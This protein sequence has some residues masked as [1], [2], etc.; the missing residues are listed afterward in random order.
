M[1][2]ESDTSFN[3]MRS[4]TQSDF[5]RFAAL[6]GDDNPIHVD[7]LFSQRT[8]FGRT[9]A[10][11]M[12]LYASI[13]SCINKHFNDTYQTAHEMIFPNPTYTGEAI[14]LHLTVS[15]VNEVHGT[16]SVETHITRA[17]GETTCQA[18]TQ[19]I[20]LPHHPM[21]YSSLNDMDATAIAP[22][23][24]QTWKGLKLG[25]VAEVRRVFSKQD[26]DEYCNL[27]QEGSLLYRNRFYASKQG[28]KDTPVPGALLGGLFSYLLGT[29]L[30]GRG[31]NWLK[32]KLYFLEPVYP[33]QE[34]TATVE[35]VRIRPE[36]DLINLKTILRNAQGTTL[37]QGEALVLV[38]DL[39]I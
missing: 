22:S 9:V 32:Q 15:E 37:C 14:K 8:K 1:E 7:P 31:T 38:K 33:Q 13:S 12:L 18:L 21:A 26:L 34:L 29:K 24:A 16:T 28:Y 10:H 2:P 35:I 20:P 11:G 27:V 36:K 4:F 25:Q 23:Q 17:D 39:E 30:P 3:C 6:S 19:L 5:D